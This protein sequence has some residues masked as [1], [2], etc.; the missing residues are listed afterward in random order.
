MAAL[1]ARE[2]F[3][4]R[5]PGG[6]KNFITPQVV[7]Y[8]KIT[9]RVAYEVSEG[10]SFMGLGEVVGVT[11]LTWS[12]VRQEVRSLYA[13]SGVVR[14]SWQQ[15]VAYLRRAFREGLD[16]RSATWQAW[17]ENGLEPQEVAPAAGGGS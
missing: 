7:R 3:R 13:V 16:A 17:E 9:P 14:S 4:R 8:G 5:Y 10:P 6:G 2:M 1:S 12:P 11:V 15:R